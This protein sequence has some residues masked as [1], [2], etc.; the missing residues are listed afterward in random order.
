M[1][2]ESATMGSDPALHGDR[3]LEFQRGA[4]ELFQLTA[5]ILQFVIA[6]AVGQAKVF[7]A[8]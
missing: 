2:G 1:A 5:I 4:H 7:E 3:L 6:F 8:R